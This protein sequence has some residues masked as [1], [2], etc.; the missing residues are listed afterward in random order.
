MRGILRGIATTTTVAGER[1]NCS[2]AWS[3]AWR[4]LGA[5][6]RR[7]LAAAVGASLLAAVPAAAAHAPTPSSP[8]ASERVIVTGRTAA[9]PA[10]SVGRRGGTVTTSLHA[11]NGVVADVSSRA[12]SALGKDSSVTV[13]PD[14]P[15][16]FTNVAP[17]GAT[18]PTPSPVASRPPSAV[19]PDTTGAA[20]LARSGIDGTGTTVAVL[21]TGIDPLPDFAGRLVGGVDLSGE[22]DPY[23]DSFGHGTFVAGLIAA[24]GASSGGAYRGEAP[25][26]ALVS[27][28]VGGAAGV[29]DMATVISG[30]DWVL[31][32]RG[33]LRIGVLN[34]SLGT[35]PA[36]PTAL[37]PLDRAVEAAWRAG[38]VVVTSAGNAG[39]FNGTILTPGDDPLVITV[40]ALDD[41]GTAASGDDTMTDFSSVG[42]T[43]A[44]GWFKP[45]MVAP[46][47]SLVSL[48]A[49]GSTIDTTYPSARVGRANF[50]G[51]GTSFSAAV[52]SGAAALVLQSG[53]DT[54]PD[55]VK[56]R[57][58]AGAQRGPVGNPFVDGHGS[59]DAYAAT[60]SHAVLHQPTPA[61]RSGP[62][63]ALRSTWSSSS[64]NGANWG[65]RRDSAP[66]AAREP[67]SSRSARRGLSPTSSAW[68]SSAWNSSA[69]NSSAWNSSAWN[70][71]AW[72]SSAWNSSAW[73]S[74]AW[75]SSAWNSSAWNS[76][77][78]NSSAWNSSAWNS[79]AWN[80]SA[81]N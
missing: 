9:A 70:S 68:N 59:L 41:H 53:G 17:S 45:D 26:A 52:T 34:L 23:K 14:L 40:G 49:P 71:S 58:L 6:R 31:E 73:N 55:S 13:S 32:H 46:G 60:T 66:T 75:N 62:T 54:S 16:A 5:G 2:V 51:S 50:V 74:S 22:G 43:S 10:S 30:I 77:A 36:Q 79:S 64:W 11:L 48:R 15:M 21:D 29:T 72:N 7:L 18:V 63:V 1:P 28:K 42:P 38:I 65:N 56:A 25:G 78:W 8:G 12:R 19:F 39:P 47:R 3:R 81:W 69:W 44:D 37:N 4:G 20:R 35:V 67:R 57:L 80:S 24:N 61:P 76:S 33:Q 27:V